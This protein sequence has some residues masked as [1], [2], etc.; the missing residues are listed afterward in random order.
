MP[1]RLKTT[2]LISNFID[3]VYYILSYTILFNKKIPCPISLLRKIL[4]TLHET[5]LSTPLKR[6]AKMLVFWGFSLQVSKNF[7]IRFAR[8]SYYLFFF[9]KSIILPKYQPLWRK[10]AREKVYERWKKS[11]IFHRISLQNVGSHPNQ[12]TWIRHCP[13]LSSNL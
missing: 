13:S 10:G 7:R 5:F 2:K 4:H 1:P 3:F 6:Y 11:A 8:T 12:I 9:K